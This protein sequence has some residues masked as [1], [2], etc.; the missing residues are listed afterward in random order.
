MNHPISEKGN[1]S[2][3][4]TDL[5]EVL[6]F[7]IFREPHPMNEHDDNEREEEFQKRVDEVASTVATWDWDTID[8]NFEPGSFFHEFSMIV[9]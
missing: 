4:Q 1:K 2:R 6:V 8:Q 9:H 7:Y 3:V 5:L